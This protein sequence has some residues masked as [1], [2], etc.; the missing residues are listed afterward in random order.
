MELFRYLSATSN[1]AMPFVKTIASGGKVGPVMIWRRMPQLI[2]RM[3]CPWFLI[4]L[5]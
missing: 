2:Q 1:G 5:L 3:A 4:H